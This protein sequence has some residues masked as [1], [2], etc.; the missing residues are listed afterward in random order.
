MN[1]DTG[2]FVKGSGR[3][4]PGC[5]VRVKWG[6]G[7]CERDSDLDSGLVGPSV[8]DAAFLTMYFKY[9]PYSADMPF[10]CFVMDPILSNTS[11]VSSISVRTLGARFEF[12]A[13]WLLSRRA[14]L[15]AK[16]IIITVLLG[17]LES[18]P[19]PCIAARMTFR[20]DDSPAAWKKWRTSVG[21][22]GW[23]MT[24]L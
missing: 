15:A 8:D 12:P 16:E 23:L 22:V 6:A 5:V 10:R 4:K 14:K 11:A 1:P 24:L 17:M 20:A 21:A 9:L 7:C 19:S 13:S 3:V 18:C 2:G